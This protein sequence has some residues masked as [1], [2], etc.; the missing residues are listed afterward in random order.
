[1]EYAR[2]PEGSK[3]DWAKRKTPKKRKYD[4]IREDKVRGSDHTNHVGKRIKARTI[5]R[6][7]R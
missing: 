1:M 5:G 7:C 3:S 2:N 6:D 4:E